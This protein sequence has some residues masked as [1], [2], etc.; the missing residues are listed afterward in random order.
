MDVLPLILNSVYL[1]VNL[2][3]SAMPIR[4]FHFLYPAFYVLLYVIVSLIMKYTANLSAHPW[5]EWGDL[6]FVS[7]YVILGG[8]VGVFV[9]WL[10][11]YGLYRLRML[12]TDEKGVK[13][14]DMPP[15]NP[16]SFA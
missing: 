6:L 10:V 7:L 1:I 4:V 8:L 3:I 5:M 9:I 13:L 12:C 16:Y 2:Y 11:I 14:D 15:Y